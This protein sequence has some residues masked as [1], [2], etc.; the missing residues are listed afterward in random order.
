MKSARLPGRTPGIVSE[1]AGGSVEQGRTAL[2]Q[3]RSVM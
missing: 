2:R 3:C 1:S